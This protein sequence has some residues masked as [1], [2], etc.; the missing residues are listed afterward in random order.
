MAV[1]RNGSGKPSTGEN[2]RQ[3]SDI[4]NGEMHL[5]VMK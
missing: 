1:K 4:Q 5:Q 3:M 2:S